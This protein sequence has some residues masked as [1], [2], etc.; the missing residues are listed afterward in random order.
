MKNRFYLLLALFGLFSIQVQAQ[1]FSEYNWEG[2]MPKAPEIP[3]K[4]KDAAA[5]IIKSE[6]FSQSAFT[7]S[8]PQID[9][10][11]TYKTY[12]HIKFQKEESLEDYKRLIIPRFKGRIGDFVQVK[13][14]DVRI[15]KKDGSI[16]D[17]KVRDLKQPELTE[18]DEAYENRD[19]NYFYE[20][21]TLE[22]G[23]EMEQITVIESKFPDQGRIV[24]LYADYPVLDASYVISISNTVKLIGSVYNGMP[25]PVISDRGDMK[26]YKW[27]MKNL[28]AVPEANASGT[29]FTKDLEY[30]VYE[31]NLDNFRSEQ[32][33]FAVKNFS[34]LIYQF[35]ADF[36][37]VRVRSKKKY[38]EFYEGLFAAG[39]KTF[40]KEAAAL[41]KLEKTFILNEFMCKEMAQ[42]GRLEDFERSEGIEYF[43]LKKKADFSNILCIYRDF[44]EKNAIQYYLAVGKSRFDGDFDENYVSSTQIA[45]YMFVFKDEEGNTYTITPSGG[46]N[47]LPAN[48]QGTR[49]LMKD[50]TDRKSALQAI[51]FG[52]DALKDEA[53]NKRMRRVQVKI[54]A[55]GDTEIKTD[56]SLTGLYSLEGRSFFVNAEKEDSLSHRL[57]RSLKN[58]YKD[59]ELKVNGAEIKEFDILPPNPF[60]INYVTNIAKMLELKDD[61]F[62]LKGDAW[63]GHSIRWVSNADKRTLDHHNAFVGS[64]VEEIMLVFPFAVEMENV[65]ALTQTIDNEY[66][67]YKFDVKQ[68]K[69]NV[70]RIQ[71]RYTIK[72]LTV[73]ADKGA[74]QQ[75][76]NKAWE[77]VKDAKWVFKKK[78]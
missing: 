74:I 37:D 29:I 1:S 35:A 60:R 44:F 47:E 61:K 65:E 68:L 41:S 54:E 73:T 20:L 43:L 19:D 17:L 71:S 42:I 50:L 21:P 48:L 63:L 70:I 55:T 59:K 27:N 4:F 6:T 12:T 8:F 62:T 15:R 34:D 5:V 39:A 14:V 66:A 46:L 3:A 25:Q 10:L 38:N 45:A 26:V 2:D 11:A 67:S 49:C 53:N 56:I 36:I 33:A 9:Q 18:D 77:K 7:G 30:F 69:D 13:Y 64:D 75:E 24:N 58:R 57:E 78:G 40:G 51:T 16:L 72:Q 31:L 76:V 52:D 32:L 28:R 22:P 23:D